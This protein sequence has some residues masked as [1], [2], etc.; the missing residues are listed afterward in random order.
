MVQ[1]RGV[2]LFLS[3]AQSNDVDLYKSI[4]SDYCNPVEMGYTVHTKDDLYRIYNSLKTEGRVIMEICELPWSPLA[5]T[6]MDRFGVR[7]YIT[8]PQHRPD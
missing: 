6:V 4:T 5:A 1:S 3:V 8:L 7:W 2:I